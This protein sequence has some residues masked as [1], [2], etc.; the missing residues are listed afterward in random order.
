MKNID[1]EYLCSV[2]AGLSGIPVRIFDGDTP[3]YYSFVGRLPR[4]PMVICKNEFLRS[5]RISVT[6]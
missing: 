2:I 5:R 3:V 4:D 1:L 6:I